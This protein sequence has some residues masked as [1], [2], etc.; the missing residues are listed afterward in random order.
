NTRYF[1]IPSYPHGWRDPFRAYASF[2]LATD[3][4]APGPGEPA[5][6]GMDVQIRRN[7]NEAPRAWG[8]HDAR[9]LET[10]AEMSMDA[11]NRVLLE[12]VYAGDPIWHDPRR[13]VFDPRIF[14]WVDRAEEIRLRPYLSGQPP[15][16]TETV[17]VAYPTPQRAELEV[18]L[19]S[20]G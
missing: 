18:A 11:G 8:V 9:W 19:D 12:M 13:L 10:T 6:T 2:L 3:P 20:P 16:P 1:V 14:A 15:R 4:V 7:R 5:S 17:T